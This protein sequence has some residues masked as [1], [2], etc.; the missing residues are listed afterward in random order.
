MRLKSPGCRRGVRLLVAIVVVALVAVYLIFPAILGFIATRSRQ[1]VVGEPPEGFQTVALTTE[2]QIEL[3]AWYAPP[4]NGAVIVLIHGAGQS[5]D[6]IRPYAAMLAKHDFGI[7]AFDLR[8]HGESGGNTNLFGW[9]GAR[10]VAA[11]L[12]YLQG[13][14][15]VTSIGGLGLSLGGEVLLGAASAYPALQAIA[16]DGA[17]HRSF[18]DMYSLP[19]ERPFYRHFVTRVMYSAAQV[20]SGDTPPSP[21]ILESIQAAETTQLLLIAAGGNSAE[22]NYNSMFAEA[23]GDRATLWIVPDIGHVEAFSRFPQ[24]YEQRVVGFFQEMLL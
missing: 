9:N 8:G 1:A 17:T 15:E 6:S 12:R 20:F 7:L 21:T 13:Q 2:D 14:E 5:R 23:V 22:V 4:T 18:E 19:L 24:E 10:D 16:S 3:A 11:A